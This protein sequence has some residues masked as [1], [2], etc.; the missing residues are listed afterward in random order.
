MLKE[1]FVKG[2]KRIFLVCFML[3]APLLMLWAQKM[4]EKYS[5]TTQMFLNE[6]REKKEQPVEKLKRVSKFKVSDNIRQLKKQRLIAKPDT[7]GNKVY[8]SCFIHLKNVADLSEVYSL[9]VKIEETFDKLGFVTARVPV[10]L[11]ERLAAIDNVKQIKVAERMYLS[12]DV[13]KQKT[14]VDDLLTVSPDATSQGIT[15]KYDGTGVIMGII[16]TG[17]DFQHI[18]FKD[19][20]GNS[21]IKRGY[22]YNGSSAQ[23]FTESSISSATTDDNTEDHGT[24][25]SSTA[26]GSSVIVSGSTVTVTDNHANATYGGMAP[27]ADLYLAGI[28]GLVN[29]YLTNAIQKMVQ[30]ANEQN[31]PLVISNSWGSGLGPRRGSG[32]LADL[33]ALYFGD[34][35]PNRAILFASSN[36]GRNVSKDGEGGGYF[37][38]K[39]SSSSSS[40]LGTIMR[41]AYFSDADA[42]CYY[43]NYMSTAYSSSP[44]NCKLY[45]LN[46]ST[47]AVLKSWTVNSNT[48]SFDGLSDYYEGTLNIIKGWYDAETYALYVYSNDGLLSQSISLTTKNGENYYK[49][50]YTLAIEVYPTNGSA[51]VDMMAGTGSGTGNYNYFTNHLSTSGHTWKAGTNDM[52]VSNEATIPNAISVGAYV[53]KTNVKNYEGNTYIYNAGVLDDI[54][55]FS[56]YA[57]ASQSPTG[58]A[59]PWITAPGAQLVA[60]VNHYHTTSVDN[61]SYY[62][63]GNKSRLAVNNSSNPYGVMQGTSMATPTAA[64]IVALW[65]QA[66]QSINMDLTVNDVKDIMEQ[67]A[68]QD[69]YTT[70]GSNASRF[71]KGKIDAL[72]GI[73][74]ILQN[75]GE[76]NTDNVIYLDNITAFAGNEI[77]FP[78]KMKNET[79]IQRFQFNLYLPEGV[80][81]VKNAKDKILISLCKDRLAEDDEH[82]ITATEQSDGSILISCSSQYNESFIGNDGEIASIK[83]S[84]SETT[85]RGDYIITLKN[86]KLTASDNTDYTN[87][88]QSS[89]LTVLEYIAGDANGDQTVNDF[90]YMAIA[91]HIHGE[92]PDGFIIKNADVDGDGTIDVA[93]YIGVANLIHTGSIYGNALH[94]AITTNSASSVDE[95]SAQLNGTITVTNATKT[96]SVGFFVSTSGTPSIDNYLR[97]LV[98][99]D[100]KTG[101]YYSTVSGLSYSTTYYYRSYILYDGTY[102]YGETMSFTTTKKTTYAVGDLYPADNPVGVVFYVSNNGKSGKIAS[103]QTSHSCYWAGAK[104]WVNNLGGGWYLPSKSE[105]QSIASNWSKLSS[106]IDNGF[107]WTSSIY[108]S[109][110]LDTLVWVVTLGNY[111]GY[112]NGYTF[113]N[114]TGSDGWSINRNSALA[115]KVF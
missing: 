112:S 110:V 8:I 69:N 97:K 115:V 10:D 11:L 32:E 100:N 82:I 22:I 59:Y 60:G 78:I 26:G 21:R 27:G 34:G 40:P 68:I 54:A 18:A 58:L 101:N 103:L 87:S 23:E 28:N 99:G 81:A 71:G 17:I 88:N 96:Y 6:L 38:K 79:S 85:S 108:S 33:V 63:S 19:K 98:S 95:K 30:Y 89:T 9:G 72:A 41:S 46:N 84:I 52:C 47:G 113:E 37:V 3:M 90:D 7:V 83:L 44:L 93:D 20:N 67:T 55:V 31:K 105:L 57:T 65:L 51:N 109:G 29:T 70:T 76:P 66:A 73:R 42:G 62:Y 86:I 48:S 25:T 75:A 36:D 56:S 53:S 12:T 77:V 13:A 64:G 106:N 114:S 2:E 1:L 111:M 107:Y 102:Y 39:T 94:A 92:T 74:Y 91:N 15:T 104:S 24:H 61:S 35:H 50:A 4:N 14:T 80:T 49:S 16:D 5:V 45:V 43:S